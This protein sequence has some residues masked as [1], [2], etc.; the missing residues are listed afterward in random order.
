MTVSRCLLLEP[1]PDVE[2]DV[3][4]AQPAISGGAGSIS[5][6]GT[7]GI[8]GDD[9]RGASGTGVSGIVG[10]SICGVVGGAICGVSCG[11]APGACTSFIVRD[12]P[13]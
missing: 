5:G 6:V 3:A 8:S 12:F 13:Q 7:C 11:M 10:G 1:V 4:P 9:G 2:H